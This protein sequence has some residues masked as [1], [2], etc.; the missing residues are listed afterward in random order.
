MH[1]LLVSNLFKLAQEKSWLGELTVHSMTIAVDWDIKQQNKQTW[2]NE[3]INFLSYSLDTYSDLRVSE[4]ITF[5]KVM[6]AQW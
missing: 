4:W 2:F 5:H 6:R 1:E 3:L